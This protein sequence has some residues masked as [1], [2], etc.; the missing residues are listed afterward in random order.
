MKIFSKITAGPLGCVIMLLA[1]LSGSMGFAQTITPNQTAATLAN[2]LVG[3]GV[4]VSNATLVCPGNANGT[5]TS[6][7]GNLG[8]GSG[9]LLTS[10]SASAVSNP[11]SFFENTNNGALGDANLSVLSGNA[12]FDACVLEFDFVPNGD[13]IN[14]RYQFGSEEYPNYTCTQFNDVF[15]FFITGPGYLPNTN[16]A[17]VP[18][19]NIPVAI[20]SVNGGSATGS[21]HISICNAMGPR[22][23]F[24]GLLYQ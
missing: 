24:S 12:T 15:G 10:G 23:S 22:I 11:A 9:I 14:F 8:I 3:S 6:G 2:N 4:T 20:N 21:G 19:T 1:L 7:S 17:L 13:A 18:G 16:I 5:F